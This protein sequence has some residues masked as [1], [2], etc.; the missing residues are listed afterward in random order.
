MVDDGGVHEL[1]ARWNDLPSLRSRE[2][3]VSEIGQAVHR[4]IDEGTI[5]LLMDNPKV[6]SWPDK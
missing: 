5:E 6:L 1:A 2:M 4:W 3:L